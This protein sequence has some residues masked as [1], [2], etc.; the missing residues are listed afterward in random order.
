MMMNLLNAVDLRPKLTL[1]A[2]LATAAA[3]VAVSGFL[4]L[5]RTRQK[6]LEWRRVGVVERLFIY[7]LKSGTPLE[8][9]PGA[10]F[11]ECGIRTAEWED[12]GFMIVDEDTK[13]YFSSRANPAV[14]KVK[15]DVSPRDKDRLILS[16]PNM[17]DLEFDCPA[18]NV[19]T[20]DELKVEYHL[21]RNLHSYRRFRK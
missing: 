9:R 2:S 19:V 15:L 12:R 8:I 13:L 5:R 18:S 6:R 14:V 21:L 16:A 3:A 4:W 11:D 1:T 10:Y 7:P 17:D 20:N